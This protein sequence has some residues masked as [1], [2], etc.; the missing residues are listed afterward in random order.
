MGAFYII[1]I[2]E[3]EAAESAVA[4][5]AG[6]PSRRPDD[7]AVLDAVHSNSDPSIVRR[8]LAAVR[9]GA[10]GARG[11]AGRARRRLGRAARAH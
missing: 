3:R 10:G 11:G 6:V 5:R 9:R 7:H 2:M 1:K 4:G 8:V